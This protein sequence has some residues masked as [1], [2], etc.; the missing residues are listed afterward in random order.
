MIMRHL[1]YIG[2]SLLLLFAYTQKANA[3]QDIQINFSNLIFYEINVNH[4]F[5]TLGDEVSLGVF[6]GYVYG[7]P[8]QD[9]HRYYY[10]GPEL[11]IYPFATNGTDGFFVGIYG[12]YKNGYTRRTLEENG[13][14]LISNDYIEN[15]DSENIDFQKVA[16]GINMGFKW[17][18]RSNLLIGFNMALGRNAYY[19]YEDDFPNSIKHQV[20][21]D[22][23]HSSIDGNNIDS[24][25]WDFRV[26]FNIGYRFGSSK[27]KTSE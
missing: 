23:Y 9:N 1:K 4:E 12:R 20:T 14:T 2:I 25:Y 15:K 18:T 22:S 10:F 24:Q 21:S 11:R 27:I 3:Q 16:F 5:A 19:N 17:V 8:E 7:F 6:G 13:Y 26:G